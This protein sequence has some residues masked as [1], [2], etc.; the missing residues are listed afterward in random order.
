[1]DAK[2]FLKLVVPEEG[3]ICIAD[4]I[5]FGD[6]KKAF[7]HYP[8]QDHTKAAQFASWLD[9]KG[10]VVYYAL[11]TYQETFQNKNDKPRIK[12]T[13]KNVALLKSIWLDIDFKDC[14]AEELKPKF[15]RF[16]KDSGLP[17]PTMIVNSGGGWHVYWCLNSSVIPERWVPLAE[18][19]KQLCKE[20]DFPADHVCTSD[21][22][23]VLRPVGTRNRKY[24]PIKEVRCVADSGVTFDYEQ[25]LAHMPKIN[26]GDLPAHLRGRSVD[27]TEYTETGFVKREVDTAKVIKGCGI[28]KH[29]LQT[30]GKYCSEPM[31]NHTLL[32][33]RFLPDGAKLVHPMSKGHI[34]YTESGTMEKWQQKLEA[35]VSGPPFCARFQEEYDE[36]LCHGC[37]IYQSKKAKNPTALGYV[38]DVYVSDV[39]GTVTEPTGK[40]G[41]FVKAGSLTHDYPYGWRAVPGNEGVEHKT[42]DKETG[43]T[44]WV[45]VLDTTW[46]L[47]E[48][49]RAVGSGQTTI[50]VEASQVTGRRIEVDVP[51]ALIGGPPELYKLLGEQGAPLLHREKTHWI[52]LMTTWL[53]KLQQENAELDSVERYGWVRDPDP[54]NPKITGFSAGTKTFMQDGKD[55]ETVR[56]KREHEQIG[57]L[58]APMGS[59]EKWQ[60]AATYITKQNNP[61]FTTILAS[62]FAAPLITF[63]DLPGAVLTIVSTESG[64][65]K[66]SVMRTAQAV[67][68]SPTKAMNST[69]DTS[70][71][72]TKK[73]GFIN[74]LPAYWDEIRGQKALDSFYDVAFDVAQGKEK[75]RLTQSA[76]LREVH[77]WQTMVIA[78]SNDS[79]FDHMAQKGGHSNAA[80]AR[81][82]EIEVASGTV[83]PDLNAHPLFGSLDLNYGRAGQEYARHL[84]RNH[85]RIEARVHDMLLKTRK[86]AV[87]GGERFWCAIIATII[88]GAREAN[89]CGITNID[90]RSLAT[91]LRDNL[92]RLRRR[93][94]NAMSTTSPRELVGDYTQHFQNGEMIID[95]FPKRG[96][97]NYTPQVFKAQKGGLMYVRAG[98]TI[99][100]RKNDFITW[101]RESKRLQFSSIQ[102]EMVRDLNMTESSTVL[103]LGTNHQLVKNAVCEVFLDPTEVDVDP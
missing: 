55:K 43:E 9:G 32:L 61:A 46:R 53:R 76:Q 101:L 18:G 12:R 93:T 31:W 23:R 19:L 92:V 99:R 71:S 3:N 78:A 33:L 16:I 68:G 48:A 87:S 26:T 95:K 21:Q 100:F 80:I 62:S 37:P 90:L 54:E 35:D 25:L 30:G 57:K 47:K 73:I 91:F 64:I 1:M 85:K 4:H 79:L 36:K 81:T 40:P 98:N 45:R 27:T 60:E 34:D 63:A 59:L 82:F 69:Q 70:L 24:D 13:H 74:N 42:K 56:I 58:Y 8:F 10:H 51:G 102:P 5:E 44:V 29:V 97:Q 103:G 52:E 6:G 83:V 11:A 15:V 7:V 20:H 22:A 49:Q 14:P 41:Q 96:E 89:E 72:V 94:G 84:A 86:W 17:P 77:D 2:E 65:G 66:T 50:R 75:T 39:H 38:S 67:W 88:V 28:L